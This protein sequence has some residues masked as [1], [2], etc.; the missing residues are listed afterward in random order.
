MVRPPLTINDFRI[1]LIRLLTVPPLEQQVP[2]S[3]IWVCMKVETGKKKTKQFVD[4]LLKL[5]LEFLEN[6]HGNTIYQ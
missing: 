5:F 1:T 2:N 4:N 6:H 3:T